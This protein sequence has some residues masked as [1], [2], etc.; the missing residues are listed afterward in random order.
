MFKCILTWTPPRR[1]SKALCIVVGHT[2]EIFL[3]KIKH[4]I[5]ELLK[6]GIERIIVES[7][8]K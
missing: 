4:S 7:E 5:H 2:E 1:K 6:Q 3:D 8:R